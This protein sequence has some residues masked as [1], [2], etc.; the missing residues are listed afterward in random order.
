M[1]MKAK[2][3]KSSSNNKFSAGANVRSKTAQF[4]ARKPQK[5]EG[6]MDI[7]E[8]KGTSGA[9]LI[10]IAKELEE[11]FNKRIQIHYLKSLEQKNRLTKEIKEGID[12]YD[13]H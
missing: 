9:N 1:N 13:S 2:Q 7:G 4:N 11:K 5:P 8:L 10:K 12:L 3:E 6:Y